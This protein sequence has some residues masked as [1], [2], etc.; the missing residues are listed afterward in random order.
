MWFMVMIIA[1]SHGYSDIKLDEKVV[2]FNT[3][4]Y[5]SMVNGEWRLLVH[6]W[7]FEPEPG[8]VSRLILLKMLSEAL[9]MDEHP[10]MNNTLKKRAGLFMVDNERGKRIHIRLGDKT[11][12]VGIS[13]S[14]GHFQ[15]TLRLPIGE[16]K[17]LSRHLRER[18]HWLKYKAVMPE[19]DKRSFEGSIQLIGPEGL[20]VISDIDDTIRVSRVKDKKAALT[21]AFLREFEP[22]E[23]M[24]DLYGRWAAK[25]ASFHYVSSCPWQFYELLIEF[26]NKHH[27]PVGSFALEEFRLK[28]FSLLDAF[29]GPLE[30]KPKIIEPIL[31]QF[32]RRQFILVGDSGEKDPEV[33]GQ[34]ARK[35][36]RQVIHI[37]IRKVSDEEETD[38]RYEQAFKDVP[39]DKWRVFSDPKELAGKKK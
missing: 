16:L 32:P 22:V 19:W 36:P 20:S 3:Y 31:K 12:P 38:K 24:A 26:M 28:D 29:A 34:I 5:Q 7:I 33:Y 10:R 1:A 35:Y 39:R 6:G 25:G 23:G 37:Y 15:H 11:Y 14:N 18:P 30:T 4:G 2:F 9:D 17:E 27:I 13:E 8:S 21:N